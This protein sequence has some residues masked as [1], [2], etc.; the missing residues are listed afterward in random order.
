MEKE[1]IIDSN[2]LIA[3]FVGWRVKPGSMYFQVFKPQAKNPTSIKAVHRWPSE[4]SAWN[5]IVEKCQ[6]HKSWDDLISILIK[7]H[8]MAI[9]LDY[10]EV[11]FEYALI[12]MR[13][14]L[15]HDIIIEFIKW[16][17]I[18]NRICCDL[19]SYPM[20]EARYVSIADYYTKQPKK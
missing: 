17:C 12:R 11:R 14:N 1:N 3:E 6:Y 16:W 7:C 20:S 4:E 5:S 2:K 13:K 9:E 10:D 18:Q 8:D 19:A 15:V